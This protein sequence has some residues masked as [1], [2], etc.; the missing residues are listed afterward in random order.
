MTE[1]APNNKDNILVDENRR[2]GMNVLL[3]AMVVVGVGQSLLFAILPPIA[4]D[5]NLNEY[6]VTFIFS[7][8]ALFWTISSPFWGRMSDS[9]GRKR[10][11]LMGISGFAASTGGV[12]LVLYLDEIG[13]L[14]VFLMYPMLLITRSIFGMVCPGTFTSA[15]GYIADRTTREDRAGGLGK[16][17]AAFLLGTILGPGLTALL[18]L[19]DI[20]LP[21]LISF[22]T[23]LLVLLAI[24]LYLPENRPPDVFEENQ[25]RAK[26]KIS[27]RR[28]RI[29]LYISSMGGFLQAVI[30]QLTGFFVLDVMQFST[31]DATEFLSIGMTCMAVGNIVSQ[32]L[33][34]PYF[35]M[36]TST[37]IFYGSMFMGI[38]FF[39]FLLEPTVVLLV[40]AMALIGFGLGLNRT[41]SGAGASLSVSPQEQG[42]VAGL[43]SSTATIGTF[44]IPVLIVPMY[45]F[46]ARAPYL[47]CLLVLL[48]LF[49]A[50]ARVKRA[51]LGQI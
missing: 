10:V 37:Q 15:V 38:G 20:Y 5:F 35:S 18:V 24:H 48:T 45:Q 13:W 7:A 19:V 31:R 26:L 36:N 8:T 41:G 30:L 14:P 3:L 27:D 23:A 16:V 22:I 28:I 17:M 51:G 40:V 29:F 44:F 12:G 50:N 11:M 46:D 32:S 34:V 25:S 4:R 42:A 39:L 2:L 33:I 9:L 1:S 43:L 49:Y 21:F 6:H 47:F